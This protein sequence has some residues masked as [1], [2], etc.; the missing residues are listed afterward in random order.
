LL[1][2]LHLKIC[3]WSWLPTNTNPSGGRLA[4]DF[5]DA[6]G[7][8]NSRT[9]PATSLRSFPR[10][11]SFAPQHAMSIE[12]QPGHEVRPAQLSF[13]AIYNPSLGN[14]DEALQDQIVFYSSRAARVRKARK[15]HESDASVAHDEEENE[16]LRQ[17]GLAQGMVDFAK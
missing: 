3:Q 16:R 12:D 2:N 1:Q 10:S 15:G 7:K 5:D 6:N 11:R 9:A 8:Q 13:L 14:T 17:V 4:G